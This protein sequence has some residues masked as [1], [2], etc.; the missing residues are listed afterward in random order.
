[1]KKLTT[2]TFL[3]LLALG[4]F[5]QKSN[6]AIEQ[7]VSRHVPD[8]YDVNYNIA[9]LAPGLYRDGKI[10][11]V[12]AM[13]NYCD[14]RFGPG[15][16][17]VP[18]GILLNIKSGTFKEELK[19]DDEVPGNE[20]DYYE[21]YIIAFLVNYHNVHYGTATLGRYEDSRKEY[22]TYF[23][24]L[25]E[26]A[27]S[28]LNKP[29]LSPVEQ[30]LVRYLHQPSEL[31]MDE[32]ERPAYNNTRLQ[33][34]WRAYEYKSRHFSGTSLGLIGG[35]WMPQGNLSTLGAHPYLGFILG[36]K[37]DKLTIDVNIN[38]RFLTTPNY[39]FVQVDGVQ[40]ASNYFFGGYIGLDGAYELFRNKKHELDVVAGI[41]YEGFDAFRDNGNSNNNNNNNNG[42]QKSI[43]TLNLNVGAG[44]RYYLKHKY[45]GYKNQWGTLNMQA[46][47]SENLSY[48]G[49]QAKYNFE[50]YNNSGGTDLTGNSFTL[51]LI[52]G[53]FGRHAYYHF[54][55]VDKDK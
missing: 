12:T 14:D 35:V 45:K 22:D 16:I 38:F 40:Y 2:L 28:L 24:F 48:V 54:N 30:F 13:V 55:K 52:Y 8:K 42:P 5:A 37:M 6:S 18:L 17:T 11:T 47:Q 20:G 51:S 7:M 46:R 23:A 33:K 31:M 4:S 27:G 39:Y 21:R 50:N 1:M 9:C 41:A 53:G 10:D 15:Y 29:G 25:A 26:V 36:G 19:K 3:C 43:N 32:L 34:A 44:Y 49:L